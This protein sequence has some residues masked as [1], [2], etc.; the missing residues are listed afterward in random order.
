MKRRA[1]L[2]VRCSVSCS[3]DCGKELVKSGNTAARLIVRRLTST[4]A[5]QKT[6]CAL[7]LFGYCPR[8]I[9]YGENILDQSQRTQAR[10]REEVRGS[11]CR[12]QGEE[13][14]CRSL[15]AAARCQP[16]AHS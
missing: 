4:G 15:A 9:F 3:G 10:D 8:S 11:S 7:R 2:A 13:G 5:G 6:A 1:R 12:A 16:D 14:L